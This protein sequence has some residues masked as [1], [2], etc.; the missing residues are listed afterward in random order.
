MNYIKRKLNK[1]FGWFKSEKIKPE[2]IFDPNLY[3]TLKQINYEVEKLCEN[4]NILRDELHK[5]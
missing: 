4:L 2:D 3:G 5:S 1:W